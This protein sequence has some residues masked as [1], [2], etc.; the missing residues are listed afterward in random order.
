M[1]TLVAKIGVRRSIL[2]SHLDFGDNDRGWDFVSP[3][4]GDVDFDAVLRAL[5]RAGYR[6]PLSVEWEDSGMDREYGAAEAARF[7]RR[8]DFA[9]SRIAFDAAFAEAILAFAGGATGSISASR[10]CH[11]RKNAL[12]FEVS[13]SKGSLAFNLERINELE[14]NL[15][16][17]S[18]GGRA[19]GFRTILVTEEDHPFVEHWWPA[20]HVLGW[21]HTFVHEIHHMLRAVCG[22]GDMAPHGATLEDG[23]RAA[24]V[25]DAILRSSRDGAGQQVHYRRLDHAAAEIRGGKARHEPHTPR[26]VFNAS[27]HRPSQRQSTDGIEEHHATA[28][29]LIAEPAT[30]GP[31]DGCR[32]RRQCV[33][34][35]RAPACSRALGAAP[36]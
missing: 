25:S 17:S 32:R 20:G 12:S 19:Q 18:P 8:A 5:N 27:R 2:A 7:V 24:E 3:G 14:V 26:S 35:G 23:Y 33:R 30:N 4:H 16:G 22:D 34:R 10:F 36:S 1:M 6:G 13:G 9:P 29:G 21:E 11:G 28:S 31:K 15:V